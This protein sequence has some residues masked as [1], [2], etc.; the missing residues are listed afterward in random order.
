MKKSLLIISAIL[1]FTTYLLGN[2]FESFSIIQSMQTTKW[3]IKEGLPS[4]SIT[5]MIQDNQGYIWIGTYEGLVRFDGVKFKI[6]NENFHEKISSISTRIILQ[7]SDNKIWIGTNGNGLLVLNNSKFSAFYPELKNKPIRSLYETFDHNVWI[8]TTEGLFK[9]DGQ[10]LSR[11]D[12]GE[13]LNNSTILSIFEDP[14]KN[15]IFSSNRGGLYKINNNKVSKLSY[16]GVNIENYIINDVA[17]DQNDII[18]FATRENGILI[19]NNEKFL[20][21]INKKN[22]FMTNKINKIKLNSENEILCGTEKG[23]YLIHNTSIEKMTSDEG[24]NDELVDSILE[25][26]EGNLWIGMSHDGI[27]KLSNM[28]FF[29]YATKHGLQ[30]NT[31]NVICKFKKDF[32]FVGTDKGLNII[33]KKK[34]IRN[35]LTLFLSNIRIRHILS[36]SDGLIYIATYSDLGVVIYDP[37]TEKT[38]TLNTFDGLTGNRT[39]VIYEDSQKNIWIGTTSGL[40]KV[41]NGKIVKTYK[42]KDGLSNDYILSISENNKNEILLGTDG[43]GINIISDSGIKI[44]DNKAGLLCNIIFKIMKD[45]DGDSWISSSEGVSILKNNKIYNL[46]QK[47][48]LPQKTICQIINDDNNTTWIINPKMILSAN[49]DVLKESILSGE[50][51]SHFKIYD[52]RDGLTSGVGATSWSINDFQNTLWFSTNDGVATLNPQK[53]NLN[54]TKPPVIIESISLNNKKIPLEQLIIVSPDNQRIIIDYTAMSFVIPEKVTFVYKLEGFDKN[55]SKP[56]TNRQ[57]TYTNLPPNDYTFLVKAANNDGIWSDSSAKI[58]LKKEPF[59]YQTIFFYLLMIVLIIL[60][61]SFVFCLKVRILKKRQIELEKIVEQR[62]Y[63]L[64]EEKD[65]SDKLLLNILPEKV[66]NELKETGKSS[67]EI[68]DNTSILFADIVGFTK[69]VEKMKSEDLINE[70]N[71]IF[72]EFDKISKKHNCERI[73]TIGDAYMSVSGM[74]KKDPRHAFNIINSAFEMRTFLFNRKSKV[75]NKWEMRFG[76]NSGSIIGGVVG[77]DKYIYDV[78]GDSIN[79][80]SRLEGV[81]LPMKINLSHCT[82]EFVKSQYKFEKRE[83]F[84]VKSKG[85]MDM[86][87]VE[88]LDKI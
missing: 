41:T 20:K 38:R 63:E 46:P 86:Y 31:I 2:T 78:F 1:V 10:K 64:K 7:T 73:K 11:F 85:I 65:K 55:W 74:S 70:L 16:H 52:M 21:W 83:K 25:D 47:N 71:E 44:L 36:A 18:Y 29:K 66:A 30:N 5:S 50:G 72:T 17:I 8:G 34:I 62:T 43:G 75:G 3:G 59:F 79:T 68:F 39:R 49:T 4:N 82:Y 12:L 37:D 54:T 24:L 27:I 35:K 88:P 19:V 32:A 57:A 42:R 84:E 69:K 61:T 14:N 60:I 9:F 13:E 48:S 6:F 81:S 22:G 67:T 40:N 15:L 77:T 28:K 33:Y 53:I 23:F 26:R 45:K 51:F 76:I 80:A 58:K 56:T 87:F